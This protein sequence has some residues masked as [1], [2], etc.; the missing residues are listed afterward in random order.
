MA[1]IGIIGGSGLYSFLEDA[2]TVSVHTPYGP[3]SD[4]LSVG[5]VAGRTVAFLPRHGGDHRF[6]PHSINY[7]ANVWALRSI[8]VH[9]IFAPCAVG[10]LQ[11]DIAPGTIVVPDQLINRTS[12]RQQTYFDVGAV[13]VAFSDPYCPRGRE[14]VLV[15]AECQRLEALDGGTMVVI[16]GP[17]FSTRAESS[18]HTQQGWSLVNMTGHPEAILARELAMCYTAIALVTDLDAGQDYTDAVAQVDVFQVLSEHIAHVRALLAAAIS[19]L[20]PTRDCRCSKALDDISLP[21]TI[22]GIA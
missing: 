3:P 7:R 18:W 14:A 11:A 6:P 9:Q 1:E 21:F 20:S 13:H 15:A 10:S 8:G 4:Q 19:K 17:R 16:D 5:T 12:G 2:Q 22:P